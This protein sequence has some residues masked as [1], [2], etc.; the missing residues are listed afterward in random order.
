M[1]KYIAAAVL[2]LV[3]LIPVAGHAAS[4]YRGNNNASAFGATKV[5]LGVKG[6]LL[7]L[8]G[9]AFGAD[10]VDITNMG[11]VFGGHF[12]D[13]LAMEFDYTQTVSAA[14][15]QFL[16]TDVTVAADTIGLLL[17]FRTTGSLYLKG[18]LGYGWIDQDIGGVGKDT[19]Y[20]LIGSLGAGMEFSD[21]FGMEVEYTVYPTADEFDTFGAAGDVTADLISLNL[22]FSYD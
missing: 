8:E 11:F 6:G 13:Y 15:E 2:T 5:Y 1:K 22:I 20:G 12:N 4:Y 17:V 7:S 19:I 21:T 3:M 16:G 14:H 9:D 10:P 18:R